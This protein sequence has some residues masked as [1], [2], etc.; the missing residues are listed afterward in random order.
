MTANRE[1]G[2]TPMGKPEI[3]ICLGSSCFARGNQK[4][5]EAVERFLAENNLK[6]E[7]DVDLEACL[8]L[9]RCADG[10]IVIIDGKIYTHVTGN[11]IQ[12]LLRETLL[13]GKSGG[14]KP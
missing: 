12:D 10:P 1:K 2:V 6:D 4:N 9:G 11:S 13:N 5:V 14:Q 7:V 3:R 8:C